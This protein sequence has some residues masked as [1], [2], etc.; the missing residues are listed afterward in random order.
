M[1]NLE[2]RNRSRQVWLTNSK[3]KNTLKR[4][5]AVDAHFIQRSFSIHL[6]QLYNKL[7][8][9]KYSLK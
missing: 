5:D 9:F 8:H 1:I 6:I 4:I 2:I 7:K 3:E